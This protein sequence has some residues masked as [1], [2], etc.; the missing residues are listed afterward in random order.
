MRLNVHRHGK[1]IAVHPR[2]DCGTELD[3]LMSNTFIYSSRSIKQFVILLDH[4]VPF[5]FTALYSES[6][7]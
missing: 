5:K 7:M 6:V 3:G 4:L 2:N 1:V